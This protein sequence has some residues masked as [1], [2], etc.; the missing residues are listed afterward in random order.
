M[1]R[2]DGGAPGRAARAAAFDLDGPDGM[3]KEQARLDGTD[4]EAAYLASPLR[5]CAGAVLERDCTP[6][7][8]P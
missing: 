6:G 8:S 7:Q 3:R 1:D 4:L 5:P 2:L